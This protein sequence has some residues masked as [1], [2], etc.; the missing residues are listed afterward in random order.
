L[1][2]RFEAMARSAAGRRPKPVTAPNRGARRPSPP[3]QQRPEDLMFFPRLRNHAKWMFVFLAL[4]FGV[5]FVIFGVGSSLPS[6]LGDILRN[7]G[8]ASGQASVSDAQ[9]EIQKD[10][11]KAQAYHDLSQAYQRNGN[12][13]AA[14]PPLVT[15]VKLQPKNQNVLQELAGLY[16]IQASKAQA[17]AAQANADYTDASGLSTLQSS[18]ISQLFQPGALDKTIQDNAATRGQAAN[19]KMH[20]AYRNAAGTYA[21][22]VKLSPRDSQLWFLDALSAEQAS[23]NPQAI[24]AYRQFL[25]LSPNAPEAAQVKQR[26]KQLQSGGATGGGTT[27]SGGGI[28]RINR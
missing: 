8:S 6:G 1:Q 22:L 25:K 19:A 28:T 4:V 11:K 2:L 7:N 13:D 21:K 12:I 14:I 17:D 10:P 5:G 16:S 20:E 3:P 26:I 23:L 24:A 15:Y 18:D 27:V 9:K